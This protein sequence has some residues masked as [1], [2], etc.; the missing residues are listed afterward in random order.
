M[1]SDM[2]ELMAEFAPEGEFKPY[3]Y[4]SKPGDVMTVYVAPAT[5]YSK[6]LNDHVSLLLSIE[7]NS[8]VGYR[9]KGFSDIIK[10]LPNFIDVK[11]P[12]LLEK[13]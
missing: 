9:I 7:D 4:Y 1:A 2:N 3:C 12:D 11:L 5:D 10:D 13:F 6:R 8:L